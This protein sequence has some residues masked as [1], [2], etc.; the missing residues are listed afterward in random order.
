MTGRPDANVI[1]ELSAT[2]ACLEAADGLLGG[3]LATLYSFYTVCL[4]RNS[5][6][7]LKI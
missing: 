4:G 6:A 1:E 2:S 3:M 7:L 5:I